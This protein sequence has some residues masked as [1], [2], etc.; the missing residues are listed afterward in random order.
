MV[1]DGLPDIA[2]YVLFIGFIVLTRPPIYITAAVFTI[3]ILIKMLVGRR[4]KLKS[5][6]YSCLIIY[7]FLA[8]M[9]SIYYFIGGLP[10]LIIAHLAGIGAIVYGNWSFIKKCDAQIKQ[11]MDFIIAKQKGDSNETKRNSKRDTRAK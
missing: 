4:F 7:A 6:I 11:Q 10:A 2:L 3:Y 5:F 9:Y 8:V 1:K